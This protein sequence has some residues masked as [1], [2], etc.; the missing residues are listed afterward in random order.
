MEDYS[1][2]L[3]RLLL[4]FHHHLEARTAGCHSLDRRAAPLCS[5][6]NS[7]TESHIGLCALSRN[8]HIDVCMAA[9]PLLISLPLHVQQP[10]IPMAKS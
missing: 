8:Q 10:F 7:A 5:Y 2:Y 1:I 4:F 3:A 6:H 9:Y